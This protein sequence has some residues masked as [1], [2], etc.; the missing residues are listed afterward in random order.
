MV[1]KWLSDST[2]GTGVSRRLR[3]ASSRATNGLEST[4][5]FLTGGYERPRASD[6]DINNL[7]VLLYRLGG[8]FSRSR[9]HGLDM[10]LFLADVPDCRPM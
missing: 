7:I 9:N 3:S 6:A 1:S 8:E 2:Q 10:G 4:G 5:R